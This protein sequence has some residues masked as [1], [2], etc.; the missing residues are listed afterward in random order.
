[1]HPNSE[2]QS[3]V[4]LERPAVTSAAEQKAEDCSAIGRDDHLPDAVK[5]STDSA[6]QSGLRQILTTAALV[7]ALAVTGWL[8]T[9]AAIDETAHDEWANVNAAAL[10]STE[11][12][13]DL[14]V[15]RIASGE[16]S[17]VPVIQMQA[18]DLDM[19]TTNTV[20]LALMRS[21]LPGANQMLGDRFFI[22]ATSSHAI[23]TGVQVPD[24]NNTPD[25]IMP[26]KDGRTKF[27]H[28][29]LRDCCHEDGDVV[30]IDVNGQPYTVVPL[31]HAGA[32]I[33]VPLSSRITTLTLRGIKDG[34]GGI[35][36]QLSTSRGEYFARTMAVGEEYHIGVAA[37]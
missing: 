23:P 17:T 28:L 9:S 31:T 27:F 10:A 26:L 29:H 13:T 25:L 15:R 1:M 20:R 35:T 11:N 12:G 8:T 19:D 22:D 21:D 30:Q 5:S 14:L 33:S 6:S 16:T 24:L 18:A 4:Q 36:I 37:P 2:L 32:T 7:A 3:T 34:R